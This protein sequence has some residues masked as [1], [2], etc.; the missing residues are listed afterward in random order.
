MN[1]ILAALALTAVLQEPPPLPPPPPAPT[2]VPV[3]VADSSQ[4]AVVE[5][6]GKCPEGVRAP[7]F[8]SFPNVGVLDASRAGV[9]FAARRSRTFLMFQ[10]VIGS[11]GVLEPETLQV[12]G[13]TARGVEPDIRR[14]LVQ[15]RFEPARRGAAAVRA[16]V[17]M[18]F[19]FEAEGTSWVKYSYRVTAR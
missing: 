18:R 2:Q 10:G 6:T 14:G 17:Q 11:D 16:R 9:D 13:G 8:A 15:A 3:T 5:C 19:E 7:R 12:M 1:A 4:P